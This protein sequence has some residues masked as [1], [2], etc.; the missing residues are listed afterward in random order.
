MTPP[1]VRMQLAEFSAL[2]GSGP[3]GELTQKDG[4]LAG[5]LQLRFTTSPLQ[6]ALKIAPKVVLHS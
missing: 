2:D 6:M 1:E 3:F 4:A 5:P